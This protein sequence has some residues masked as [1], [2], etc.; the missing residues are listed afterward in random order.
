MVVTKSS[1]KIQVYVLDALGGQNIK[2][3]VLRD[4]ERF[5]QFG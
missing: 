1:P 3:P 4:R 2:T 5:V